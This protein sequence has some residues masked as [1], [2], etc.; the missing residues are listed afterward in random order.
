[1]MQAR[2]ATTMALGAADAAALVA[3]RP[4]AAAVARTVRH[5]PAVIGR[6]GADAALVPLAGAAVWLAA[7][8]LG[9]GLL[10]AAA[11]GLPGIAG[12]LATRLAKVLLPRTIRAAVAGSA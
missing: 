12:R 2:P 9:A 3:L 10:A 1:M 5:L 8:G 11:S 7:G 6:E 4:D